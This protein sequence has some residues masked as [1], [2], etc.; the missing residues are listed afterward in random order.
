MTKRKRWAEEIAYLEN[1]WGAMNR[2]TIAKNLGRSYNA[3]LQKAQK[4][5]LGD[6]LNFERLRRSK[7]A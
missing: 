3:V 2:Q 7:G 6:S 1:K 5:G 4:L